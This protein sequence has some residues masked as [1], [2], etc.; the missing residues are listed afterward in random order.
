MIDV[1]TYEI[2]VSELD[3]PRVTDSEMPLNVF[4]QTYRKIN[5]TS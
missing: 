4:T 3:A 5:E 2:I 1:N